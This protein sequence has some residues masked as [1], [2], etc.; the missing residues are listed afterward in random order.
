MVSMSHS[1]CPVW[2]G[3]L[4][5]SPLRRLFQDPAKILAP[6]IEEGMTIL[7]PGPG[8]EFFTLEMAKRVGPR[9]HVI[10][11]DIQPGML[12]RLKRRAGN[13]GLAERIECRLAKPE[14]LDIAE[15]AGKVDFALAFAMVHE[16]TSPGALIG[17]IAAALTPGGALLLVEPSG[18]VDSAAFENEIFAAA[19]AGLRVTERPAIRGSRAALLR[20]N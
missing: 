12:E 13:A 2:I 4:L 9:G 5:A 7:E 17:E 1:V 18:H 15:W 10:A 19:Q 11:V 20:R 6:Y 16:T 14:S 3:R 8:M